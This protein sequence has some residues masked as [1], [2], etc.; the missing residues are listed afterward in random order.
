MQTKSIWRQVAELLFL[1]IVVNLVGF[2]ASR[3]MTSDTLLWYHQLPASS[4][5]PPDW[6]F[7]LVWSFLFFLMAISMFLVWGRASPKWFA[8]QLGLNMLWSFS[9]FYL[10]SPLLAEF[11]LLGLIFALT[12]NIRSF[13][14][15][16]RWAGFL[17]FPTLLW[18]LFALYLNSFIIYKIY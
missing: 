11:V 17:L 4:F 6:L 10:R 7:G 5:T 3:Y 16:S 18:S 15:V 1:L 13:W 2:I 9:F 8:I 12:M 14:K